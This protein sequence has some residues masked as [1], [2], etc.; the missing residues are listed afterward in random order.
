MSKK[1][2]LKNHID[3]DPD[4]RGYAGMT[5]AEIAADMNI[6]R[7]PADYRVGII[8]LVSKVGSTVGTSLLNAM[9]TASASDIVVAKSL[10]ILENGG[11]LNLNDPVSRQFIASFV[12]AALM[13]QDQADAVLA[14][15]DNQASDGVKY[16]FGKVKEGQVTVARGV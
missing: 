4:A 13:T 5:D 6:D 12:S 2:A 9:E 14:L 7:N 11:D 10:K 8:G 16:G 1:M 15:A 3:T